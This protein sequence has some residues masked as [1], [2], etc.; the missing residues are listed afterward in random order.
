M[1]HEGIVDAVWSNDGDSL[2][3]G[4]SMVIRDVREKTVPKMKSDTHVRLYRAASVFKKH[5]LDQHGLI[6]FALLAGG[7]YSTVGL[8]GCGPMLA[9]KAA[10]QENGPGKSLCLEYS[11]QECLLPQWRAQLPNFLAQKKPAL[12]VPI[13]F[14]CQI[15]VRNY[16]RPCVSQRESL[17]RLN[18]LQRGWEQPFEEENLR[19]FLMTNFNIRTK[20]LLRDIAPI[21]LVRRSRNACTGDA[22]WENGSKGSGR[23]E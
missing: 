15:A 22:A 17:H 19:S 7:D 4:A 14:P 13:D 10:Q 6:L 5:G 1:Q 2:M 18:S 12:F 20:K 3:F 16:I 9:L 8:I 23:A 11:T 21:M